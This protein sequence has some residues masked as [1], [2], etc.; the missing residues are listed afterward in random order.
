M[1]KKKNEKI[2]VSNYIKLFL[3]VAVTCC[4]ALICRNIYVSN[5]NYNNSIPVI[6]DVLKSEIRSSEV[7][8]FI[9]ENDN[10]IIYIGVSDDSNCRNLEEELKDVITDRGLEDEITYLNLSDNKKRETFIKEFNKFYDTKLLGYPSF[11]IFEDGKVKDILTVKTGNSLSI[12]K[13]TDFFDKN[14]LLSEY[15]D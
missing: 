4:L 2:P 6:S 12:S 9:R 15:Y 10:T 8:N 14:N 13:V 3:L 1:F 7:Y 5:I 11:I